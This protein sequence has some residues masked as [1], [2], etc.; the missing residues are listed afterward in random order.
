MRRTPRRLVG[1]LLLG[2]L[3]TFASATALHAQ[4]LAADAP[5]PLT[6]AR[7]AVYFELGG[8]GLLYSFNYERRFRDDLAARAGLMY[9]GAE[10]T[11][12]EGESA[13]VDV[14]LVPLMLN[15]LMGD[16]SGRF[17][18]GVGPLFAVAGASGTDIE[19]TEFS[20]SGFG[21]AGVTSTIGY[22]YQ[23]VDGGI[24]FRAGLVPFWSGDPQ[25]WGGL[26]LGYAF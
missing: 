14:L 10:G 18:L 2:L 3:A 7:N 5:E 8:N 17:E 22:R 23:P 26:S 6:T 11:T 4:E 1:I 19:G 13:N 21:P 9:I 15:W 16:G 25:L 24:V 20:G 12:T